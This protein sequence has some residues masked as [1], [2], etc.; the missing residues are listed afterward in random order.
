MP[1]DSPMRWRAILLDVLFPQFPAGQPYVGVRGL[2]SFAWGRPSPANNPLVV[3]PEPPP[4]QASRRRRSTDKAFHWGSVGI[5]VLGVP[6]VRLDLTGGELRIVE[7]TAATGA[8]ID[9]VGTMDGDEAWI[10]LRGTGLPAAAMDQ[11][12]GYFGQMFADYESH[13]G[14]DWTARGHMPPEKIPHPVLASLR[15]CM[16]IAD[17]PWLHV[18]KGEA[19]LNLLPFSDM[20][21]LILEGK[22][23]RI[24]G[25]ACAN[26]LCTI[27]L[28]HIELDQYNRWKSM[29]PQR[30]AAAA[31]TP[32]DLKG[33]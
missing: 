17:A 21:L 6:C 26:G 25:E 7:V 8:T 20:D 11:L 19:T 15:A 10:A 22:A 12:D 23:R 1:R 32:T 27:K 13:R 28:A 29:L 5:A 31:P 14:A 24:M 9:V 3:G 16:D 18:S 33:P 2:L 4:S 30:V